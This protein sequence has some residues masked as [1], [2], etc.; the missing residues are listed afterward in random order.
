MQN[1]NNSWANHHVL[2][3]S[4]LTLKPRFKLGLTLTW[5]CHRTYN[6]SYRRG[7]TGSIMEEGSTTNQV[8][9]L[10]HYYNEWICNEVINYA[11]LNRNTNNENSRIC[12]LSFQSLDFLNV[13]Q[14][15]P[16]FNAWHY[17]WWCESPCE[18]RITSMYTRG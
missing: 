15:H 9:T 7:N 13:D 2:H 17:S 6:L 1:Y 12:L 18:F 8:L 5:E 11:F 16:S 4:Y 10:Q 14:F 3:T